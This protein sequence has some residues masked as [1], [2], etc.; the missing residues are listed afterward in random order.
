MSG[1]QHAD[2]QFR[3]FYDF[4]LEALSANQS[5]FGFSI[6]SFSTFIFWN[7]TK[8]LLLRCAKT[9]H[10]I[11]L[12]WL[13]SLFIYK[14]YIFYTFESYL[15]VTVQRS[16]PAGN[17]YIHQNLLTWHLFPYIIFVTSNSIIYNIATAAYNSRYIISTATLK[18]G[19]ETGNDELCF[20][21]FT[22]V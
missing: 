13:F 4:Q 10:Q 14:D 19:Q 22:H 8:I 15:K 21:G 18:Y 7:D 9:G 17:S 1:K 12:Y 3:R 5:L 20:A 11:K 16:F 2:G 6:R